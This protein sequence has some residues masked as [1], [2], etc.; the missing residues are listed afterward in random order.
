MKNRPNL[1]NRIV[2]FNSFSYIEIYNFLKESGPQVITYD[3]CSSRRPLLIIDHFQILF[4]FEM[5]PISPLAKI[6][7]IVIFSMIII[8]ENQ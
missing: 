5:L 4:H 7:Q 6:H 3:S 2:V 1:S 8:T